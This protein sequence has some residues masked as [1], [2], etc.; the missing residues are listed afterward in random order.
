MAGERAGPRQVAG[1]RMSQAR[2]LVPH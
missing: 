1:Q 2:H